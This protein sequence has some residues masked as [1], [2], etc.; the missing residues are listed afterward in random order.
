M[1]DGKVVDGGERNWLAA[2]ADPTIPYRPVAS[3][4]RITTLTMDQIFDYTQGQLASL[5]DINIYSCGQNRI[6]ANYNS[7]QGYVRSLQATCAGGWLGC[8]VSECGASLVVQKLKPL[9]P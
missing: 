9:N 2:T 3:L 1:K 4:S 8:G 6:E 7:T 5:T